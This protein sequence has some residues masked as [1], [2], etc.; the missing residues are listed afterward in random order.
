MLVTQDTNW[1]PTEVGWVN[2]IFPVLYG[3]YFHSRF[4]QPGTGTKS[5][6][7][8]LPSAQNSA[9]RWAGQIAFDPLIYNILSSQM[10]GFSGAESRFFPAG[11]EMRVR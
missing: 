10:R 6:A 11:R 4:S 1:G 7:I 9:A 2:A 5:P 8:P 3:A